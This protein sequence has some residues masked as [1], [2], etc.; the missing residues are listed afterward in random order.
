M[1][2]TAEKKVSEVILQEKKVVKIGG[3]D[4][5][6]APPSA[7]VWIKA[8]EIASEVPVREFD[9]DNILGEIFKNAGDYKA[10]CR[11]VSYMILGVD[12]PNKGLSIIRKKS[13]V[14]KL[15]DKLAKAPPSDVKNALS[16]LFAHHEAGFFF[17]SITFLSEIRMTKPTRTETTASGQ[18]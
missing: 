3:V 7:A 15:A 11:I 12:N 4:Y 8:S 14:E 5:E 10:I 2:K 9:D 16:V 1:T 13:E 6:I 18:Q 17:A